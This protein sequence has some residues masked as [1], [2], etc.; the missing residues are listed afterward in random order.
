[1]EN[2]KS[3]DQ[4]YALLAESTAHILH[5]LQGSPPASDKKAGK[6][7]R[8]DQGVKFVWK[9]LADPAASDLTRTTPV[10]RAWRNTTSWL[11]VVLANR[12]EHLSRSA[13]WK[14]L[15]YD[16]RLKV[17]D[18]RMQLEAAEFIAWRGCLSAA[19]LESPIWTK[20]FLEVATE[21]SRRADLS[22]ATASAKRFEEWIADGRANGLKRQHLL[23]RIATGWIPD[24]CGPREEVHTSE[25]DDLEGISQEQLRLAVEY[26]PSIDS[27]LAAQDAANSER[28]AWG[29]QW[30]VDTVH[31]QLDWPE[32]MEQLPPMSLERFKSTL[33]SFAAGTGLGWDGV[34]PRALLRLP[35]ELLRLWMALLLKCERMGVWPQMVG[36]VVVVLM[37][38]GDTPS[39]LSASSLIFPGFGCEPDGMKPSN[40]RSSATAPS[41]MQARAEAR[42]LP[43]G[44]RQPEPR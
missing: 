34:H 25:L 31:D 13:V 17:D 12:S 28:M 27:P 20:S 26:S 15:H 43:R 19:I 36:I 10:S 23:S 3:I 14:L 30:A 5:Q 33:F 16:H 1:V 38:K 8:W 29:S 32:E 18:P 37:P 22:A 6:E 44:N 2:A 41:C 40:G 9:N 42:P 24:K 7:A 4:N 11:R 21:A 39:A 35:D